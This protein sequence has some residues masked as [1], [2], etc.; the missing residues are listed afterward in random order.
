MQ[1][2][3]QEHQTLFRMCCP[4]HFGLESVLKFE[5]QRLGAQEIAAADGRV[6]FQAI[7]PCWRLPT[8]S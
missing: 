5:L 2:A 4:C 6:S 7:M 1:T 8:S 3:S